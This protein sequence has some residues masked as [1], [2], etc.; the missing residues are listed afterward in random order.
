MGEA[1][2]PALIEDAIRGCVG[3]AGEQSNNVVR[4]F[5]RR[6]SNSWFLA[7]SRM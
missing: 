6:I 2:I 4:V 5:V 1:F 3:Q 7:N